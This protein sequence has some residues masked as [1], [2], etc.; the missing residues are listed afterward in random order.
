[1]V[2]SYYEPIIGN[3]RLIGQGVRNQMFY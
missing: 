1:L 3:I 2:N